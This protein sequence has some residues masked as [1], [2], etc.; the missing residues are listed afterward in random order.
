[1]SSQSMTHEACGGNSC[2]NSSCTSGDKAGSCPPQGA[3]RGR[4]VPA[5]RGRQAGARPVHDDGVLRLLLR[6]D[7]LEG[8]PFDPAQV[9]RLADAHL[10]PAGRAGGRP[11]RLAG[12][13]FECLL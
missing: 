5:D 6:P 4:H 8:L 10:D 7:L 11:V 12:G 2:T 9:R 13:E 1:M 3:L